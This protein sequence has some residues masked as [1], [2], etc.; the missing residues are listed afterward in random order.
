MA[1]GGLFLRLGGIV[2][3]GLEFCASAV[4]LGIFS[5][6]LAVLADNNLVIA[7][8][9]QAVEGMSGAAVLYTIFGLVFTLCL[10][11]NAF[12]GFLAIVLDICFA[13]CF[14]AIAILTRHGA[15]SCSGYVRTPLGDGQADSGSTGYGANGFGFGDN[16]NATYFPNLHTACR[17]NTAVFAVSIIN[18]FLF[19][20]T[21][22]YQVALVRH[23]RKEKRFGPSPSNNYTKGSGHRGFF[24][25][26]NKRVHNTRDAEAAT[27]LPAADNYGVRPSGETGTT[28][29][30]GHYATE[31]K[32]GQPGYGQATNY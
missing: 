1:I 18:I 14:I 24:W 5:Y 15:G 19:L 31:P 21:A 23:H 29:G 27:A 20:I 17:L 10:G 13:G 32:I 2:L 4:A 7:R 6:F 30:N 22:A 3:R 11:G 16:Q 26:K 9:K 12:F 28:V 25:N 8:W